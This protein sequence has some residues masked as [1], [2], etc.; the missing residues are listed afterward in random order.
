MG[1]EH[2]FEV[3]QGKRALIQARFSLE[4]TALVGVDEPR[5][6]QLELVQLRLE[7]LRILERNGWNETG[8]VLRVS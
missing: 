6:G 3:L 1:V 7:D 2:V 5:G 8:W 4:D